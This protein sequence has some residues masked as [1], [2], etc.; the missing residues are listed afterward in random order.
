MPAATRGESARFLYHHTGWRYQYQFV[1]W[2][3]NTRADMKTCKE[4]C[5]KYPSAS[6]KL[7][8][9]PK[10]S[11]Q[12][13]KTNVNSSFSKQV[14]VITF[15]APD[16]EEKAMTSQATDEEEIPASSFQG[17]YLHRY[18]KLK[19]LDLNGA[20]EV[21]FLNLTKCIQQNQG[22][23]FLGLKGFKEGTIVNFRTLLDIIPDNLLIL[24]VPN[25]QLE[26]KKK[27]P[28]TNIKTNLLKKVCYIDFE[29]AHPPDDLV[30]FLIKHSDNLRRIYGIHQYNILTETH[31]QSNPKLY[32]NIYNK[33]RSDNSN[34]SSLIF[35]YNDDNR[36]FFFGPDRTLLTQLTTLLEEHGIVA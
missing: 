22:L 27:K 15:Q 5:N 23:I 12:I 24:T 10:L 30:R 17:K 14:K 29:G 3:I 31:R 36:V 4:Y 26:A 33:V 25:W 6:I 20:T 28:W 9:G 13:L 2:S 7:I 35:D 11:D 32:Q 34:N 21:T 1:S 8:I 19:K 18:T 16:E